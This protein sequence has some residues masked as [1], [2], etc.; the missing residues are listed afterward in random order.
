[1]GLTR[2]SV[3]LS[4]AVMQVTGS[5]SVLTPA[6]VWRPV[7]CVTG[8]LSVLTRVTN[9]TGAPDRRLALTSPAVTAVWRQK[10]VPSVTVPRATAWTR[11][12]A[13]AQTMTSAHSWGP[14]VRS[15]TTLPAP[16]PAP[17]GRATSRGTPPPPPASHPPSQSSSSPLRPTSGVTG[18]TAPGTSL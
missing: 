15:V 11:T 2:R 12:Q 7:R 16:S 4:G 14:A 5:S 17:A 1:M 6:G 3:C 8:I 10:K 18:C 13:P 9:L